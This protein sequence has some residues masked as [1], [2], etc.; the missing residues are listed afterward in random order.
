M[1]EEQGSVMITLGGQEGEIHQKLNNEDF[2][3]ERSCVGGL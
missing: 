3:M 2:I 1:M